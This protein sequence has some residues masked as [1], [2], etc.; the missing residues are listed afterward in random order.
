MVSITNCAAL[1]QP[2]ASRKP[3]SPSATREPVDLSRLGAAWVF[4]LN[5][6]HDD[7]G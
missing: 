6:S 7:P 5:Y 4:A 1:P 2:P 3:S